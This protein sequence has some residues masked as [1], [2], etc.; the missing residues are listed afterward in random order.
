MLQIHFFFH[1]KMAQTTTS[2]TTEQVKKIE[3]NYSEIV[4]SVQADDIMDE[5]VDK[6]YFSIRDVV[7]N[8]MEGK[9]RQDQIERLIMLLYQKRSRAGI[10]DFFLTQLAEHD[11]KDLARTIRET[12]KRPIQ[13]S[14]NGAGKLL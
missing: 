9:T 5:F 7:E 13:V 4:R 2:M 3:A 6:G 1:R 12:E 11:N 8:I 14:E 10:F